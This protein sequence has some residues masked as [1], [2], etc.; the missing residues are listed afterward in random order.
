MNNFPYIRYAI[1]RNA[2]TAERLERFL[3]GNYS[4]LH[5]YD[6]PSSSGRDQLHR[7]VIH[8]RD[9]A[10][11]TLDEYV[12]PRLASGLIWADEVGLDDPIFKTIPDTTREKVTDA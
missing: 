1:V 12:I 8:G 11:W 7:F 4:I 5:E 2:E 9:S 10:G 6:V 3:P